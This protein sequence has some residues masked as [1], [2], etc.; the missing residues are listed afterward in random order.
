MDGKEGFWARWA[1]GAVLVATAC[2]SS[3]SSQG[4][5]RQ[6]TALV[7]VPAPSTAP[8]SD[9]ALDAPGSHDG[10]WV[11]CPHRHVLAVSFLTL[12]EVLAIHAHQQRRYPAN[13]SVP[14][15]TG[16]RPAAGP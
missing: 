10:D 13:R 6:R 4:E 16:I 11:D 14:R 9:D 5:A 12:D 15:R 7:G 8:S 3:E 1:I 2:G